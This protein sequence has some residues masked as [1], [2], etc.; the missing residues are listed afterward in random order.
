MRGTEANTSRLRYDITQ[1]GI[2]VYP[3]LQSRSVEKSF[4]VKVN[5]G[6]EGLDAMLNGGFLKDSVTMVAGAS[7]TGK[8]TTALH[9]IADGAMRNERGLYIS[10]EEPAAQLIT[11]GEGFGW[12]F[13][14]L[15]DSGTLKIV[16][17]YLDPS[18]L[19][20]HLFQVTKLLLDYKPSRFVIDS[21]DALERVMPEEERIQYIRNL[22]SNLKAEGVTSLCTAIS[23]SASP[24][25]GTGIS[26]L[27]DSMISLR[28]VE[29]EST[30]KRSLVI[31]KVRGAAHD[32]DIREFEITSRGMV[33]KEKF[34]GI[35]QLLGGAARRSF[36]EEAASAWTSAFAKKR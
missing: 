1:R 26:T 35:E 29:L 25:T 8:T 17:Y 21:L 23:E 3:E 19:G 5:T 10:F 24:V 11:H 20:E 36:T 9:F 2:T 27:M 22:G 16:S 15:I 13:K 33:V 31:F 18:K 4:T 14:Q 32:R 30:L 34:A 6:I 12:N 28:D 7:G